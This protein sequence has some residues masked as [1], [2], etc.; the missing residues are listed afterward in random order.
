MYVVEP[1]TTGS[2]TTDSRLAAKHAE[3]GLRRAAQDRK[4]S[5]EDEYKRFELVLARRIVSG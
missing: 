1:I 2:R 3:A 4:C 5:G